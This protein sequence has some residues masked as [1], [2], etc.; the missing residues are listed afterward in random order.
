MWIRLGEPFAGL[1]MVPLGL[2]VYTLLH[3]IA[4]CAETLKTMR[5]ADE[6]RR[7]IEVLN[8]ELRRQVAERSKQLGEALG[9]L[10]SETG[11]AKDLE[12]GQIIYVTLDHDA[13][14][15]IGQR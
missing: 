1:R 11:L 13:L 10:A 5:D 9:R 2:G 14:F 7:E 12:P 15:P 8:T 3:L 6:H 4:I